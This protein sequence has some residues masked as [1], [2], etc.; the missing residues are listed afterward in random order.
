MSSSLKPLKLYGQHGPNPAKI[1]IIL[2]EL[3]LPY[4][5]DAIP[6][7]D[8]KKPYY[9]AVNPNGRLPSM[10]DANTDLTIWESG[11]I[12]EYLVDT[13]D[14]NRK[15]SFEPGTAEH[16]HARQWL[17]FQ[18]SGQAP[19]YGQAAWFKKFH[20]EKVDS[21][22]QRYAAETNR[23]SGVL[24]AW[25]KKQ[26]EQYGDSAGPWMVGNKLSYVDLAFITWQLLTR[27]VIQFTADEFDQDKYP[28]VKK[29]IEGM[30][31][32]EKVMKALKNAGFEG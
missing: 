23:V 30:I 32:K 9:T 8:V 7:S 10:Y 14:K 4:E 11:A 27:T 19:Y 17:F 1:A 25:L 6:F 20:H 28:Y 21:A 18:V 26:E 31:S 24:D 5:I 2:E 3:D 22:I 15:L 12:I 16:W 13:Y 29:W